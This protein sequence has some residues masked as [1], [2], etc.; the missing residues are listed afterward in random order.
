[1]VFILKCY[2]KYFEIFSFFSDLKR[3]KAW[4]WKLLG[5]AALLWLLAKG[6]LYVSKI[7]YG[8]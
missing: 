8:A 3:S 6:I 5:A 2:I 1:M 4:A 7:L